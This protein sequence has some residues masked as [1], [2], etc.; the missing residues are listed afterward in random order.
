MNLVYN[1]QTVL[2]AVLYIRQKQGKT[3]RKKKVVERSR[4]TGTAR[5]YSQL[6][7]GRREAGRRVRS[8]EENEWVIRQA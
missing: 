8:N 7:A 3:R 6:Y 5:M 2:R 1:A 4:E